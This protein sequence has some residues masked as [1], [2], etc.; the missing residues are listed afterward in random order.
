MVSAMVKHQQ[1]P[2]H[3]PVLREE[4]VRLLDPQ[5][6]K[7]YVD[8]TVGLGGHTV[9]LFEAAPDITVVGIDCDDQALNISEKRL[10]H[11]GERV[12]LIHGNYR[13]IAEH[14][15]HLGIK[16]VAGFLLDLGLS[17]LQLDTAS[18]GF[19]FQ[20]DGPLD[21]RMNTSQEL[22]ASDLVNNASEE[23]LNDILRRHGEER[24]ASRIARAI[25]VAREKGPIATT[26]TL[27]EI[28]R[29]A[30]PKRY[31]PKRIDPSTRTFQALRIAVNQELENLEAGLK[32][33]FQVLETGGVIAVIS[34]HSLE[35]RIVKDFFRHKALSCTCP[36]DL[37]VCV[38][39]KQVEA[40]ILTRKP[41]RPSPKEVANNPR[42]RS[43]KLRAARKVI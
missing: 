25:I 15:T 40:E 30:I 17:S 42:A 8:G 29:R 27:A 4:V 35:D 2:I 14:L 36:P 28:V 10:S 12:H 41:I 24:F 20:T 6:D 39:D 1:P 22:T 3:R 37:P 7:I 16:K 43:A 23:E 13:N 9:A 31:H 21:M 18:R 38:C 33:G 11:F 26:Q 5:P 32:T 34:F 19:S